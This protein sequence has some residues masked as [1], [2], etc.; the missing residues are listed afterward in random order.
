MILVGILAFALGAGGIHQV[1][2]VATA[3]WYVADFAAHGLHPFFL[4]S[5]VAVFDP[6]RFN[7]ALV[8]ASAS[9]VVASSAWTAV[10]SSVI[11]PNATKRCV[12]TSVFIVITP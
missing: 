12:L 2:A 11:S 7:F 9:G 4:D 8:L 10:A 1:V 6:D 3:R 5:A